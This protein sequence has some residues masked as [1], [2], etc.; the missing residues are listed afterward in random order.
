MSKQK[1]TDNVISDNG[2]SIEQSI[3]GYWRLWRG[4][5]L[6]YDDSACEDLNEDK[7]TA[8]AFFTTYLDE[9]AHGV[10]SLEELAEYVNERETFPCEVGEIITANGWIDDTRDERGIC[11]CD[12]RKVVLNEKGIAVIIED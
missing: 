5:N 12:D 8:V 6:I 10:F 7:D 11:S 4:D 9:N 1:N 3:S 2:Y